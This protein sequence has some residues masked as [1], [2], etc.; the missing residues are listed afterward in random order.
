MLAS[1]TFGIVT[2]L[3]TVTVYVGVTVLRYVRGFF[4]TPYDVTHPATMLANLKTSISEPLVILFGLY[5]IILLPTVLYEPLNLVEVTG[6]KCTT[7][8]RSNTDVL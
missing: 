5:N 3:R 7:K 2:A 4:R 6:K 1:L 8:P